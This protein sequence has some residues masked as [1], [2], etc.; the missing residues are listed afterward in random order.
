MSWLFTQVWL[1]SLAAFALGSLLTWW[2]FVRPLR[3]ELRELAPVEEPE[4]AW[5]AAPEEAPLDLLPD[6]EE[7]VRTDD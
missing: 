5:D 3:R 7:S 1:W 2:L 6:P 4:E